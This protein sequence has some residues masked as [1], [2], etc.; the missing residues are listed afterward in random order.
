MTPIAL[1]RRALLSSAAALAVAACTS[2]KAD[3]SEAEYVQSPFRRL[4][5]AQWRARLPAPS[6]DVLRHKPLA[7]L[8]AE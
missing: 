3:A 1:H 5:D 4:T 2:G 8:R 6:Y 7:T